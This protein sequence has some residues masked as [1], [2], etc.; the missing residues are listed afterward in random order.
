M[1]LEVSAGG[2]VVREREGVLEVAVIRP[3]GKSVWALPKGHLDPGETAEQTA[4]REVREETGLETTLDR[5][6][7]DVRYAYQW[8]G[9]KIFKQVHFFL[10]RYA[11]GQIDDLEP[12]MRL[13]VDE[14]RWI[15]LKDAPR[16]LAYRGERDI[17][18][19][20]LAALTAGA[21]QA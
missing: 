9:K 13:E 15:P 4:K 11:S 10:L 20:A 12:K 14:A 2:V 5:P 17:A 3:R 6:L 7:G 8:G 1:P 19:R 21:E 18:S 16:S